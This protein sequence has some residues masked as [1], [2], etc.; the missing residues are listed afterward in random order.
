MSE[1]IKKEDKKIIDVISEM[2]NK[3]DFYTIGV[4]KKDELGRAKFVEY[5]VMSSSKDNNIPIMD[6]SIAMKR[7]ANEECQKTMDRAEDGILKNVFSK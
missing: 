4:F 6:I 5:A 3:G 7:I 2:L 1:E